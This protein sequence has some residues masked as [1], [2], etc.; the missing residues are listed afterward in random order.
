[1][2]DDD[3]VDGRLY[4]S[5]CVVAKRECYP[6]A[7]L[8]FFARRHSRFPTSIASSVTFYVRVS[9]F[10][11]FFFSSSVFLDSLKKSIH[12]RYFP[13]PRLKSECKNSFVRIDSKNFRFNLKKHHNTYAQLCIDIEHIFRSMFQQSE[14]ASKR[15]HEHLIL[16]AVLMIFLADIIDS[17]NRW[18]KEF[19]QLAFN[20]HDIQPNYFVCIA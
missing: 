16:H 18:R 17:W 20:R 11:S 10:L 6:W 19:S 5:K 13:P 9:F 12:S 7:R 8:I 15:T 3:D 14:L 1:M 2:H 4:V